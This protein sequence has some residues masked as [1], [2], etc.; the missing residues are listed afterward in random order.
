VLQTLIIERG[1]EH[2]FSYDQLKRAKRSL[3]AR[4][5]KKR[6]A[7]L[8]S[9]WLWALPQHAPEGTEKEPD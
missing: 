7:G 1:A 2:G 9:P 8:N 5:F 6:E 4:A 3:G